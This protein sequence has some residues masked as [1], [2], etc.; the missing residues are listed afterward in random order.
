MILAMRSCFSAIVSMS[1][2]PKRPQSHNPF[3]FVIMVL[4]WILIPITVTIFYAIPGLHAQTQLMLGQYMGFRSHQNI[5][6]IKLY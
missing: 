6:L 4:Q 3:K 2:L 1:F 5:E